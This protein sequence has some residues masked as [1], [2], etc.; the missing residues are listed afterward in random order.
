MITF[1]RNAHAQP[2]GI[3]ISGNVYNLVRDNLSFPF[4]DMGEQPVKN[5][6][7]PVKVY[8]LRPEVI[9]DL[10]V[11]S[12]PPVPTRRTTS[13]LPKE[14]ALQILGTTIR[15]HTADAK[16]L[17]LG[18]PDFKTVQVGSGSSQITKTIK[19][20]PYKFELKDKTHKELLL[21]DFPHTFV[22]GDKVTFL[23]FKDTKGKEVYFSVYNHSEPNKWRE[24]LR[25]ENISL[26]KDIN[27]SNENE[28]RW[29]G[30]SLIILALL[31][32]LTLLV[33]WKFKIKNVIFIPE[34]WLLFFWCRSWR[35]IG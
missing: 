33:D 6:T 31:M 30:L 19:T 9:A 13:S 10:P 17:Q 15:A 27:L 20:V 12:V 22:N 28:N 1:D 11:P 8:A 2:G 35:V 18:I 16:F 24:L 23:I 5:I 32:L 25:Y 21:T 34:L 26:H 3:C 7:R 14:F 29:A 4:Q